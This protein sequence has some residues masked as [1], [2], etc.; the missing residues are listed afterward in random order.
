[1]KTIEFINRE[2]IFLSF[3]FILQATYAVTDTNAIYFEIFKTIKKYIQ[4]SKAIRIL[5]FFN[6]QI[7][8]LLLIITK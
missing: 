8:L 4:I 1:M 7:I 6:Q 5:S 3:L 2:K